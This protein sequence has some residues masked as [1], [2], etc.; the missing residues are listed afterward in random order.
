[1]SARLS[2]AE[3]LVSDGNVGAAIVDLEAI[4]RSRRNFDAVES[5]ARALLAGL[6]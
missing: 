1:M 5:S 3:W 6:A 2:R 4:V